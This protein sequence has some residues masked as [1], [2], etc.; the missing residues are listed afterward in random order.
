[1]WIWWALCNTLPCLP[2]SS[3]IPVTSSTLLLS[4]FILLPVFPTWSSEMIIAGS[5][6]PLPDLP[7]V[8]PHLPSSSCGF[9]PGLKS[10]QH[11]APSS[12]PWR[13][14]GHS[15]EP[16]A[17]S[18]GWTLWQCSG[19]SSKHRLW[20]R[21]SSVSLSFR[22]NMAGGTKRIL[23]QKGARLI[24]GTKRRAFSHYFKLFSKPALCPGKVADP[25]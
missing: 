12:C 16:R 18:T 1:M 24:P 7:R 22:Q 10:R 9:S 15:E 5:G 21:V 14:G 25:T 4:S 23:L 2:C 20:W 3:P 11:P 13:A 17:G 6:N 8:R 19:P